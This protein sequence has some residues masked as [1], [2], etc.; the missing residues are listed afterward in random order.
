MGG[1]GS[2]RGRRRGRGCGRRLRRRRRRAAA[3]ASSKA[4][5][6]DGSIGSAPPSKDVVSIAFAC[7]IAMS[8]GDASADGVSRP[9]LA[10]GGAARDAPAAASFVAPAAVILGWPGPESRPARARRRGPRGDAGRAAHGGHRHE[11]ARGGAGGACH[12]PDGACAPCGTTPRLRRRGRAWGERVRD[13]AGRGARASSARRARVRRAHETRRD[14]RATTTST[15]AAR[16]DGARD[17]APVAFGLGSADGETQTPE[18]G[19]RLHAIGIPRRRDRL[20]RGPRKHVPSTPAACKSRVASSEDAILL[21]ARVCD[22][23]VR[24]SLADAR[25]RARSRGGSSC[26]LFFLGKCNRL[27]L[28]KNCKPV[29]V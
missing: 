2:R 22:G 5:G 11:H 8:M 29:G 4:R 1:R 19:M 14:G 16:F 3:G 10:R 13:E 17:G 27:V 12:V 7:F 18:A 23:Q 21:F 28:R 25:A 15:C 24:Q 20:G 9:S 26:R 6:G